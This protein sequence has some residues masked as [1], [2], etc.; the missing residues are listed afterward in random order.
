MVARRLTVTGHVQGVFFRA[1]VQEAAT[2][3]D[4]AGWA[5]N[6]PDGSVEIQLE[7]EPEAVAHVEAYCGVGPSSARVEDVRARDAEPEGLSSFETR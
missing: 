1:S 2:A 6:E 7:G 5:S 3:N 4:V